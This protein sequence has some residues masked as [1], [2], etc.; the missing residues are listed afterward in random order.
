MDSQK[1]RRREKMNKTSGGRKGRKSEKE[2][3]EKERT[4]KR[5]KWEIKDRKMSE[6]VV[7]REVKRKKDGEQVL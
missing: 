7:E 4:G 3:T 2:R 5:G 1:E 6:A